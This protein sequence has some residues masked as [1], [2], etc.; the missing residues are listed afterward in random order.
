MGSRI[1]TQFDAIKAVKLN[2]LDHEAW[3]L[4]ERVGAPYSPQGD[5]PPHDSASVDLFKV[6]NLLDRRAELLR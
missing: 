4:L 6:R 5:G 2:D 3:A 1:S